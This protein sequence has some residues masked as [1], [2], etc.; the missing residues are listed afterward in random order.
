[1]LTFALV[2]FNTV[3]IPYPSEATVVILNC[4]YLVNLLP[5]TKEQHIFM[6]VFNFKQFLGNKTVYILIFHQG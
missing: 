1:M 6:C 2:T 3:I 5:T 4:Y